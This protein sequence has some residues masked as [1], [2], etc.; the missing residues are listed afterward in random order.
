MDF[1]DR[2]RVHRLIILTSLQEPMLASL[3]QHGLITGVGQHGMAIG[4]V[5]LATMS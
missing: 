4:V 5:H 3:A 2:F 1:P